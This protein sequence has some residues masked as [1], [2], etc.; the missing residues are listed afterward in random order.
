L[1]RGIV[2]LS[3]VITGNGEDRRGVAL[4]RFIELGIIVVMRAGE[5]NDIAD[6]ITELSRGCASQSGYHLVGHVRL[7]FSILDAAGVAQD[8]ANHLACIRDVL[9]NGLKI[10]AQKVVVGREAQWLRQRLIS[11]VS[12]GEGV[13]STHTSMRLR[14]TLLDVGADCAW[15]QHNDGLLRVRI[16]T[17]RTK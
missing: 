2:H 12:V 3:V 14:L 17:R 11:G 9:G 15:F 5:L 7:K 13:E 16:R 10:V 8:V 1:S 4:V 6:V